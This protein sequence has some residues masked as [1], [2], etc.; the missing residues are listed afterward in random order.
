MTSSLDTVILP[1]HMDSYGF[2]L[3][4]VFL[5]TKHSQ[6]GHMPVDKN[7]HGFTQTTLHHQS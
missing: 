5:S 2:C 7:P 4:V 6:H 1:V 3:L